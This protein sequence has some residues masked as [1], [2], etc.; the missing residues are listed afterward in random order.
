VVA[1]GAARLVASAAGA[2]LRQTF[3]VPDGAA[4]VVRFAAA[5]EPGDADDALLV[6]VTTA[7]GTRTLR[8]WDGAGPGGEVSLALGDDLAGQVVTLAF[9]ASGPGA[10]AYRIDDVV[11]S[12]TGA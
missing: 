5:T 4:P 8:S 1:D 11:V 12:A 3:R 9:R 6:D 10:T 7:T 2:W